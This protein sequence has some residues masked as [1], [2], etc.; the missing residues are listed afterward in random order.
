MQK[1]FF[2]HDINFKSYIKTTKEENFEHSFFLVF[3]Q[4][5]NFEENL[6]KEI[7]FHQ[8]I[9]LD[10]KSNK[11]KIINKP[12]DKLNNNRHNNI[13]I[14]T[15]IVIPLKR[16]IDVNDKN[17]VISRINNNVNKSIAGED[18]TKKIIIKMNKL[19][20]IK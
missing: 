17:K 19:N 18:V 7:Y 14:E 11:N 5:E 13:K 20:K 1:N 12:E 3:G 4:E 2:D 16:E 9:S 15:K 8:H 10:N 6:D